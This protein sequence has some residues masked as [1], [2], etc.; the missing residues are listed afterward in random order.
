MSC[1][2]T[3]CQWSMEELEELRASGVNVH[4]S[5]LGGLGALLTWPLTIRR[6]FDVLYC[7]GQGRS[8]ALAKRFL[9]PGGLALYHEVLEC[10]APKSVA[11]RTMP[12]MDGLI[13][14]SRVVGREMQARWPHKPVRVIPFLTAEQV[15]NE[16]SRRP[17]IDHRELRVVYLG[18]LVEYKGAPRLIRE[19]ASLSQRAALAPARLDIY[20]SD[21]DPA[22]LPRLRKSIEDHGLQD[23]VCCHGPYK[24]GDVSKILAD[25]DLVVLP[26]EWEGLPLVLVEAMQYGV[27]I[28]ATNVGGNTELGDAN[29]DAII[30][31]PAWEP[32]VDGLL[33]MA[34]KLRSGG[35][36]AV[37]LHR[38]A[39]Q[40]YGYATVAQ[41]W[42]RALL[43]SRSYFS[44]CQGVQP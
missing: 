10:P 23:R 42:G 25:A 24:H 30:T 17:P 27:P 14:N 28:V 38:W 43:D 22:T 29:P 39:E 7:I 9:L 33:Q 34:A 1:C 35:V 26:S 6:E 41:Q 37:R 5:K 12:I 20:G 21:L 36:D 3:H 40:R 16:P 19:W 13:A 8:H 15:V 4:L 11:A 44:P 18:R 31:Q 32:F 2:A